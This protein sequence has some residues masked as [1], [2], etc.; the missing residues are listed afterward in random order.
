M[1]IS[2]EAQ[3]VSYNE[4]LDGEIVLVHFYEYSDSEID[5]SK[6]TITMPSPIRGVTLSANYEFPPYDIM[7]EW[8]D[9]EDYDGGKKIRKIKL[10]DSSLR[11]TLENN[12]SFDISFKTDDITYRNIETFLVGNDD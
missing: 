1:Y 7:V 5:Y 4:A 10:T 12:Y 6:N 8:C 2:F 3:E 9:G 11:M